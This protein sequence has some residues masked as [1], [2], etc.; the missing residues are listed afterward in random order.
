M[1]LQQI[2]FEQFFAAPRSAVFSFM[3]DH[4]SFGR[5][6]PGRTRRLRAAPDPAQPDGVGSVRE[7]RIGLLHFEETITVFEPDSRIEYRVTRGGN[8]R[9]HQ[10]V[11]QFESVPGG[12]RMDYSIEFEPRMQAFGNLIAAYL[13]QGYRRRIHGVVEDISH[14]AAHTEGG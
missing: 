7:I 3:A 10:G 14:A 12:T 11:I 9:S 1:A 4:E 2:R 6:W 5:L 8:L 13:C